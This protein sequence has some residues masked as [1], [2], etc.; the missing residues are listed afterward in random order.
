LVRRR[1]G[2]VT[3]E[4]VLD[5]RGGQGLPFSFAAVAYSDVRTMFYGLLQPGRL[6]RMSYI[7]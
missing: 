1:S 3:D 2:Y 4:Y 5:E 7:L 6:Q